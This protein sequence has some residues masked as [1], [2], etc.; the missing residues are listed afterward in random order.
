MEKEKDVFLSDVLDTSYFQKEVMNVINAPCGCGKTTAVIDMI[1]PLASVPRK[2]IYLI[3]T[4]LGNERLAQHHMDKLEM[5][6]NALM[7]KEIIS[8]EEFES[9][10]NE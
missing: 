2:A 4:K 3:D 8:A 5:V 7:Q 6:A 10:F 9:F 1:L